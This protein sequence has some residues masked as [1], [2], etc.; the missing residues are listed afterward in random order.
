M[1]KK[2]LTPLHIE[3]LHW[4]IDYRQ[5]KYIETPEVID[6]LRQLIKDGCYDLEARNSLNKVVDT[7]KQQWLC[8]KTEP[9]QYKK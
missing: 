8:R 2:Y 6:Y 7:Y 3:F 1:N 4:Y 9:V 5:R